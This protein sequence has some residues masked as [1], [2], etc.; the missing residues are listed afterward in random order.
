MI[1]GVL[2]ILTCR[3]LLHMLSTSKASCYQ[4]NCAIKYIVPERMYRR[5]LSPAKCVNHKKLTGGVT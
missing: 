1:F 3:R 4:N 2:I 5:E